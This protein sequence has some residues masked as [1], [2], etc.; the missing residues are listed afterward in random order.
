LEFNS[1]QGGMRMV[2]KVDI[3]RRD[4]ILERN[5]ERYISKLFP[6][7][8]EDVKRFVD[9]LLALGYSAGRVDKYLN[10]LVSIRKRLNV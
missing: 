10:S 1:F 6:E 9:D 7:D 5:A 2:A 4:K 8:Q 3:H